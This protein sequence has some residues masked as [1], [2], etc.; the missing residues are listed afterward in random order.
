MLM[1]QQS[2]IDE[3][4]TIREKFPFEPERVRTLARNRC[5]ILLHLFCTYS[6]NICSD[7]NE[8]HLSLMGLLFFFDAQLHGRLH[9]L[10][11]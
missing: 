10:L 1:S 9:V 3:S 2:A 7:K 4:N 8:C 11:K 5:T 6:Q